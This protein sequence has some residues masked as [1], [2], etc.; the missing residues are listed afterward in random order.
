[1]WFWTYDGWRDAP[2]KAL[3]PTETGSESRVACNWGADER[4]IDDLC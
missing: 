4:K 3:Q 1:M 2:F